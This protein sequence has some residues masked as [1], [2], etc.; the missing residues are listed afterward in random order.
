MHGMQDIIKKM[1]TI[2]NNQDADDGMLFAGSEGLACRIGMIVKFFGHFTHEAFFFRLDF[3]A[4]VEHAVDRAT[5][6]SA[7][8]SNLFDGYHGISSFYIIDSCIFYSCLSFVFPACGFCRLLEFLFSAIMVAVNWFC[9]TRIV[10]V[11]SPKMSEG[12]AAALPERMNTT[13]V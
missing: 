3:A 2:R 8:L 6:D 13:D 5:R 1:D 10:F 4:P 7:E 9:D 11:S 12:T